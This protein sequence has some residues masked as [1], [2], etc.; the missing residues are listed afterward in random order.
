[1]ALQFRNVDADPSWPVER[2]PYEALVTA[3]DR[4]L[5]PHWRRI[6]SAVR[7]DPWGKVARSIEDYAG[8]AEPSGGLTLLLRAV[9]R[10][11]KDAEAADVAD[12]AA[13]V[14]ELVAASGLS[15]ADFAAAI[16]TSTSRL[17]TYC[18]GAVTPSAA[19][20]VRMARVARRA[21]AQWPAASYPA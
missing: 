6:A 17:S 1:V 14:R 16:G 18:T 3:I 12:V 20:M 4:G 21:Q 8:Y 19:L 13:Q 10:A 5:L 15:R 9:A 11:R 2:W 7:R